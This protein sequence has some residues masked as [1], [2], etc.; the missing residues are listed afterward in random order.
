MVHLVVS[1]LE[2]GAPFGDLEPL[3]QPSTEPPPLLWQQ[4]LCQ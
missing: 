4:S 2:W 3:L 1:R